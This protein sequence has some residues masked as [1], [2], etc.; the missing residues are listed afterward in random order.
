MTNIPLKTKYPYQEGVIAFIDVL[1]FKNYMDIPEKREIIHDLLITLQEINS[2]YIRKE[3][4][5]HPGHQSLQIIANVDSYADHT[6]LSIPLDP[7]KSNDLFE[8]DHLITFIVHP[9]M[10]I[11]RIALTLGIAIRGAISYGSI[12]YG[13][14]KKIIEG[15][16]LFEAMK[17]ESSIA[18]YPR[19]IASKTLLQKISDISGLRADRIKFAGNAA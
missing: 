10:K 19:V 8:I 12:Y 14:N 16:S 11:Q 6:I 7:E 2:D 4:S 17:N 18:K 13:K 3:S 9:I 15:R 1:G 5:D